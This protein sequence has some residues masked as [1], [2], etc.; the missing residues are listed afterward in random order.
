MAGGGG[1]QGA[2]IA[3]IEKSKTLPLMNADATDSEEMDRRNCKI[4]QG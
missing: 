2:T 1:A 3:G 4:G